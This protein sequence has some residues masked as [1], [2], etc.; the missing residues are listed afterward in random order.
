MATPSGVNILAAAK[1]LPEQGSPVFGTTVVDPTQAI[2]I[3]SDS[4]KAT[5]DFDR[6][7]AL[8]G[9]AANTDMEIIK[10]NVGGTISTEV[11]WHG[12]E[13][14]LYSAF[15]FMCPTVYTG[16]YGTGSGGSP[17]PDDSG[18]PAA[19]YHLFEL[20]DHLEIEAWQTGERAASSGSAGDQTYWTTAYKK[21]RC[22]D[23]CIDKKMPTGY[24]HGYR[25][26]MVKT[27][28][29]TAAQGKVS[30]EWELVGHSHDRDTD[31]GSS[32][33][34]VPTR[35]R[36]VF[37]GLH[38]Y[39]GNQ[40]DT[41]TYTS[42]EVGVSE[43]TL[44]I[45]NP[46]EQ[47]WAS[48]ANSAYVIEPVR[49]EARRITGTLKTAR[50][51]DDSFPLFRDALTDLQAIIELRGPEIVTGHRNRLMLVLPHLNFTKAEYPASGPGVITGDMEFEA[52]KPAAAAYE[53]TWVKALAGGMTFVKKNEVFALLTN[54]LA[55]CISRDNQA[56]GVTLP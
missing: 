30:I 54:T 21:A 1:R 4:M 10:W 42:N 56:A 32:S 26:C 38:F 24:V 37:T 6:E 25:S 9:T 3:I 55:A 31:G 13:Y 23:L 47:A 44:K 48:G 29:L 15:G 43:L 16:D 34:A 2:P 40:N 46:V 27:L 5:P 33:W 18:D 49:N 50:Y 41:W 52:I 12:I 28:T 19:Y 36:A 8:G 45:E 11:W 53:Y 35:G 17:A 51:S 39:V 22:F 7:E 20:D 14:L